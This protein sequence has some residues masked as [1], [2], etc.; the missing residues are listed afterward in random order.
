[1][2]PMHRRTLLLHLPRIEAVLSLDEDQVRDLLDD[3]NRIGDNP[4]Q[5]ASHSLS[6][7]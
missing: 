7:L 2:K 3:L 1:M 4:A 6:D 5:K